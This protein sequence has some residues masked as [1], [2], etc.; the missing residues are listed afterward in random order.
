VG[1]QVA[2]HA[3]VGVHIQHDYRVALRGGTSVET[4]PALWPLGQAPNAGTKGSTPRGAHSLCAG[5]E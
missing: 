4:A 3:V 2:I 5:S 1:V